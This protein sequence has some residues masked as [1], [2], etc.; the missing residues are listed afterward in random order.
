MKSKRIVV[1]G[2]GGLTIGQAGEFDYSGSQALKALRE[3]GVESIVIN[4]N[5]ATVQTDPGMA[6]RIYLEPLNL[7]SVE[8]I[9]AFEKPDGILLGFGGQIALNLGIELD[10]RGTLP[11]VLGT[12]IASIRKSEDREFFKQELISIGISVPQSETVYSLDDAIRAGKKIG[13]PLMLRANY[14]LGGLGSGKIETEEELRYRVK[15]MHQGIFIEEFLEGWKEFE[16]EVVRDLAGQ[17]LVICSMENLDP[18][19]IH[20][21]E[22]VVVAPTQTISNAEHQLLRCLSLQIAHH[23]DIVGE[24]NIQFAL[25]KGQYRVIEM[26]ARLSRSSALASKA[27][28]YPL[29]YVATKLQLGKRLDEIPNI[30]TGKGCAFFEPALDYIVVKIPRWDFQKFQLAD[31]R[32][33]SEMKSVGEVMAIGR[34]FPEALQKAIRMLEIN[35]T[36]LDDPPFQIEDALTE[37]CHPTDQRLFSLYHFFRMGGTIEEAEKI[38]HIDAWFLS[39]I[40]QMSSF[41]LLKT[42]SSFQHAKQ[43][44]FSDRSMG[45]YLKMS[46]EEVRRQRLE[47]GIKPWI[48]QIDALSGESDAKSNYL[49]LTYWAEEHDVEPVPNSPILILGSGP[50]RIGSSVEFDWCAVNTARTLRQCHIPTLLINSNPETVSTDFDESDRLYFEELTE[51]RIRD[52]SDF[53]RLG[54]IIVSVGGQI[55]NNRAL[56]LA[57][58][59]LPILGTPVASIDCA[60]DREQFSTLLREL[61]ISQPPWICADSFESAILFG[62]QVLYPLLIRPSYVLSGASMKVVYKE[63]DLDQA[64]QEAYLASP[65]HPV[66]ISKFLESAREFEVDGVAREGQILI[67]AVIEHIENAGTHSGDATLVLPPQ[68]LSPEIIQH[69]KKLAQQISSVLAIT[70]PFNIQFLLQDQIVQVIECNLRASRSFPFVSKVT[71]SNLIDI[72]TRQLIE[73]QT[74]AKYNATEL[75]H[76][77]IKTAQFSYQRMR[78]VD[79]LPSVE[80]MSTGEVAGIRREYFDA[81][82]LSWHATGQSIPKRG[83]LLSIYDSQNIGFY[84]ELNEL[85]QIG[86]RLYATPE[87]HDFFNRQGIRVSE[88]SESLLLER[89]VDL[90]VNIPRYARQNQGYK[91]RRL[92]IDQQIPLI[93]NL[94]YAEIF[95]R[96]L[97]ALLSS[98]Y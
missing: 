42:F 38:S 37:L 16:Y 24:C 35:S 80:M 39:E 21:G 69:A 29:A 89:E 66:V 56:P 51:E 44:G 74:N 17:A 65:H 18:M 9:L 27:T 45:R 77:G 32:L 23:F 19:G 48:K 98:N 28:G 30:I 55:A 76:V 49:Y 73:K 11:L 3:E 70:G 6:D 78:G 1:L 2:S 12:S 36:G 81:F 91:I 82:F 90:V 54:G 4:P 67:E 72:A 26:N 13:Y 84:K 40:K 68:T 59:G 61:K 31:R 85:R 93:T 87:T 34:T 63:T 41:V 83:I 62:K 57:R 50:Y 53:E 86:F 94:Q 92:A 52:I 22:S 14:C 96:A 79:P 8:K 43:L 10:R 33:G 47:W 58:L 20:T 64:M 97:A 88:F 15:D 25:K 75:S 60:E 5:I 95:L 7:S 46:E 71:K